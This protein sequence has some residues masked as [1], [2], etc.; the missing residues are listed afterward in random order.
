MHRFA[1]FVK[2]GFAA[3]LGATQPAPAFEVASVKQNTS[4]ETEGSIG[5]RPGGY[6]MTNIPLRLL[7][8]R[9][10]GLR[11]F[12]GHRFGGATDTRLILRRFPAE[13]PSR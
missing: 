8:I 7:I 13:E 5:P 3:T 10:Y 12:A 6:A 9:A 1:I 4:G 11:S 2:C